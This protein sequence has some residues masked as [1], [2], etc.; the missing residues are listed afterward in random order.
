VLKWRIKTDGDTSEIVFDGD[1]SEEAELASLRPAG[2]RVV[3]DVGKVR[4]VNSEG[5][6]RLVQWL[7]GLKPAQ[8]EVKRCSAAVVDQL[9]LV[10]ELGALVH[11]RSM[12]V[13]LEC[14]K[15]LGEAEVLVDVPASG[16]PPIP[17]H[18]CK[19]CGGPMTMSEPAERYFAFTEA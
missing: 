14:V 18:A 5:L 8:V 2:A 12:F 3:L 7:R 9:N 4:R 10:P 6:R 17:A 16:R 1:V 19:S 13:P 11:V 15:C